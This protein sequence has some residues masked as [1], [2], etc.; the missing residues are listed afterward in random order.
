[1]EELINTFGAQL[2][3]SFSIARNYKFKHNS[4]QITNVVF[5]GMGGSGIGSKLVAQ[6]IE[7][8]I[9]IPITFIQNYDIPGWVN[10]SSLVIASSYSGNTEETI[11]SVKLCHEKGAQIVGICSGG[12]LA[13]FCSLHNLDCIVVPPGLPPRAA[14]AYSLVQQLNILK[15][16]DLISEI[17]YT[18]LLACTNFLDRYRSEIKEIAKSIVPTINNTNLV[19]YAEANY[20]AVAIRAKQQINENSKFLCRH[21]VLPEM[22]HNEL[23]GWGCGSSDHSAIFLYTEGMHRQNIKRFE[24]TRELVSRKTTKVIS[25]FSKGSNQIEQSMYL[26]HLLDWVSLYL[27]YEREEDVVEIE[28]INYL[29]EE[30]AKN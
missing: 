22:N 21:N 9:S 13:S 8:E 16:Y 30:L 20:E 27:G 15:W 28:N 14:L 17:S 19:I 1:M 23:L 25:I 12:D 10:S 29:K 5:T 18:Q 4:K 3:E 24:L 26:I 6:W 11:S 7:K 2:E